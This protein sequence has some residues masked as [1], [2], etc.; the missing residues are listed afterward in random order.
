MQDARWRW[1]CPEHRPDPKDG[2]LRHRTQTFLEVVRRRVA[3]ET[4]LHAALQERSVPGHG[5][6]GKDRA[7]LMGGRGTEC[8]TIPP[9]T[10]DRG[11]RTHLLHRHDRLK[12]ANQPAR[13][14]A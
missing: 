13:V 10:G 4:A 11:G 7:G 14:I 12:L 9:A 8:W 3:T 2:A 5:V 1:F 6:A